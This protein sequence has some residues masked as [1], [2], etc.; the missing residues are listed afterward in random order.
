MFLVLVTSC[1]SGGVETQFYVVVAPD[2]TEEFMMAVIT[3]AKEDG[4][5]TATGKATADTGKVLR[6]LEG[7]GSGVKLWVQNV[8]LGGDEDSKLCGEHFEPYPD[9]AQF[10]IFT[11]P[12]FFFGSKAAAS[13]IG[14]RV[15]SKLQKAGFDV[16]RE[17]VVCGAAALRNR[18]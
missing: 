1:S 5:A 8:S 17:A 11:E 2:Q 3:I 7:R 10:T 13:A 9:P 14:E 12:R 4:L 16:R 18:S 6:F 15:F